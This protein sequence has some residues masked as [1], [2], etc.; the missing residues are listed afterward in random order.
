MEFSNPWMQVSH[1][2]LLQTQSKPSEESC[3]SAQTSHRRHL[4]SHQENSQRRWRIGR[5]QQCR[6][7]RSKW[8]RWHRVEMRLRQ[9]SWESWLLF[10]CAILFFFFSLLHS[11][12]RHCLK[13]HKQLGFLWV[14]TV[15]R[16]A[17]RQ[18]KDGHAGKE[19]HLSYNFS[20]VQIEIDSHGFWWEWTIRTQGWPC[21]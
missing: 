10:G 13:V 18:L 15:E 17:I 16:M 12:L 20:L 2:S 21:T 5:R 9:G 14:R 6:K 8:R 4:W 19:N 1:Y 3:L 11:S 7:R